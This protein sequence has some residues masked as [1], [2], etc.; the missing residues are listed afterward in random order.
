MIIDEYKE[1]LINN[2]YK[3]NTILQ[4]LYFAK[5]Y[6][7]FIEINRK[8]SLQDATTHDFKQY[9]I[10]LHHKNLSPKTISLEIHNVHKFYRFLIANKTVTTDITEKIT[11]KRV[12]E[13]LPKIIPSYLIDYLF[14][15]SSEENTKSQRYKRN[16]ALLEF[17][18]STGA[19]SFETRNILIS[20]LADDIHS[21][22]LRERTAYIGKPAKLAITNYLTDKYGLSI[23]LV[24][25]RYADHFLFTKLSN[26]NEPINAIQINNIIKSTSMKRLKYSV[27]PNMIRN[28]FGVEML[29]GTKCIR[30]TQILMGHKHV[31][32]TLRFVGLDFTEKV[33]CIKKFHPRGHFDN[34]Q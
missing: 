31:M 13:K 16:Q 26:L 25:H 2:N 21:C 4:N 32:T 28:T 1:Y 15:P 27:T 12:E 9:L 17:L 8:L 6:L 10:L 14:L 11:Y 18:Y 7:K 34:H 22:T 5:K 24:K 30:T 23:E 19:K 33:H 29:K 20:D 3:E